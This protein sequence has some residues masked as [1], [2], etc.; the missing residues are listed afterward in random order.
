MK[1]QIITY[2]K[3]AVTLTGIWVVYVAF[4]LLVG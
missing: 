4:V 2:I 3:A 1:H